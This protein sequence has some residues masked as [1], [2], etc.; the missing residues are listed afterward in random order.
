MKPEPCKECGCDCADGKITHHYYDDNAERDIYDEWDCPC[1]CHKEES[2]K[3]K[4]ELD[5]EKVK[6][7]YPA[8][9]IGYPYVRQLIKELERLRISEDAIGKN[10]LKFIIKTADLER[11]NAK[12]REEIEPLRKCRDAALRVKELQDADFDER[13]KSLAKTILYAQECM[14]L[15]KE[16]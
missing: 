14:K 16:G 15:Q 4:P 10:R 12:L 9:D 8:G 6:A 13:A 5:L 11:E 3:D 7:F 2:A 1:H